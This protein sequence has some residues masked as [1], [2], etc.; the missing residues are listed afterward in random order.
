[1]HKLCFALICLVFS[2]SAIAQTNTF[3]QQDPN[4][5][6]GSIIIATSGAEEAEG[7]VYFEEAEKNEKM[8]DLNDALT[9]FGKAA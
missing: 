3:T 1:M 7:D 4:T 2:G 6:G 9:L 5:G 8:G